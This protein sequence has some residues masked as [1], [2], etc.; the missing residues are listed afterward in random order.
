MKIKARLEFGGSTYKVDLKNP[1]DLSLPLKHHGQLGAWYLDPPTIEP[2]RM[3][4]FVGD[5]TQGGS[6]N[7]KNIQFNP[8]A[9]ATHTESYWHISNKEQ[10]VLNSVSRSF[11]FAAVITLKSIREDGGEYGKDEV[12]WISEENKHLLEKSPE[13]VVIRSKPN[14]ESKKTKQYSNSNPPYLR[15]EDVAMMRDLGV[16]HLLID[17]P[18]VDKERDDGNLA[19]HKAFWDMEREPRRD[20]TI[21]EFIF[22]PDEL[23]DG[24]YLLELQL[25]NIE[26]DATLSR[27][28]LYNL[29]AK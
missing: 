20:A 6:V 18:S 19:S 9:H 7:F 11:F 12:L 27:P 14:D 4:G 2:V 26:N 28:L 17:L 23:E 1:I 21:T 16:K 3:E 22:V 25:A 29:T 8:H 5:V 15:P 13:A 24:Y 10:L